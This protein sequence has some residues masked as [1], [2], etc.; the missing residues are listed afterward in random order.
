MGA[1]PELVCRSH[2]KAVRRAD[3][4]SMRGWYCNKCKHI[5]HQDDFQR[6]E[7]PIKEGD[8]IWAINQNYYVNFMSLDFISVK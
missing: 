7:H 4:K 6:P 1:V 3:L 2:A 5:G 8:L